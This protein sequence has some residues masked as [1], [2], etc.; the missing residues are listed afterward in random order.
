MTSRF[1]CS[2]F[3]RNVQ[4]A[5]KVPEEAYFQFDYP[6]YP[7]TFIFK[8]TDLAKIEEA[9]AIVSGQKSNRHV[10][11]SVVQRPVGYNLPWSYHLDPASI[12]FFDFALEVCDATIRYVEDHL[13][14]AC[15]AFLPGC[16]WCPWG[17]RLIAEVKLTPTPTP[18]A[19]H[20]PSITPT[21]VVVMYLPVVLH[22]FR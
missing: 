20:T 22:E 15:G 17:S 14:E 8:L 10:M 2:F 7:E 4:Q 11:G 3:L 19:T 6:P 5:R 18:T 9:R 21:P 16:T 13:D 12:T 1:R